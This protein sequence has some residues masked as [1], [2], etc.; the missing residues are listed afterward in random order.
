MN[1]PSIF[2][3]YIVTKI[4]DSCNEFDNSLSR[5]DVRTILI[6]SHIPCKIHNQ[7]LKELESFGLIGWQNKRKIEVFG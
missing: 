3:I 6:R 4:K 1:E 2:H 5:K 7:F